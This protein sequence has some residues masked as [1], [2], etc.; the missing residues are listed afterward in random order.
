MISLRNRLPLELALYRFK[1]GALEQLPMTPCGGFQVVT[2]E[3]FSSASEQDINLIKSAA[4]KWAFAEDGVAL[5]AAAFVQNKLAQLLAALASVR[6]PI[7][8]RP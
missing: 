1:R 4:T 7:S 3:S 2:S 8:T 6:T 5:Q